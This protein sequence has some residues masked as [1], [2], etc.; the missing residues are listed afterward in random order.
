MLMKHTLLLFIIFFITAVGF[1]QTKISGVVV[2]VNKEPVPF[3]NVVFKDS[4][5]GTITDE[6]GRFYLESDQTYTTVLFTFVGYKTTE[7]VLENR[8]NYEMNVI[9]E[10]DS[11]SLE[12]VVIVSGK[13]PKKNN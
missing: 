9:L 8:V 12:E 11:E 13:Q 3:A 7:V 5:R 10:E 6:N 1:S 4:N 2:D